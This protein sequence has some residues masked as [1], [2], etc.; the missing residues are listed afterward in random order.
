MKTQ[1]KKEDHG[2]FIPK[3]MDDSAGV[4]TGHIFHE[5]YIKNKMNDTFWIL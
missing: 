2:V 5:A 1:L 4:Q 3:K